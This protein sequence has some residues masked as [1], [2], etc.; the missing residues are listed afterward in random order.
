MKLHKPI[1]ENQFSKI[2]RLVHRAKEKAF[3]NVN[4]EL[5]RLYWKIGEVVSKK[6]D[7]E[8]WG[9]GIV[10]QLADYLTQEHPEM[11]GLNRRGLY[12]MKQFYETYKDDA[13][14][15][16]LLTQLGWTNHLMILSRALSS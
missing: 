9:L 13:I 11:K 2:S 16:T 5:I 12:R 4:A 8:E 3:R 1:F 15:T 7:S 10:N 6:V 14:V